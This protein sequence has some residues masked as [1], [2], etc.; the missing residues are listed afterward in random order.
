MWEMGGAPWDK[1]EDYAR[2]SPSHY[3]KDFHTPTL[4]I[5]GEL[6]FRVPYTQG[7]TTFHGTPNAEGTLQAFGFFPDEGPLGPET[8]EQFALVIRHLSIGSIPG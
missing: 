2:W 3:A 5:H 1:P 7:S 4:V 8:A 6:D